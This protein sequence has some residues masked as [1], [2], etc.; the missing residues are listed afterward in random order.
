MPKDAR[1][2]HEYTLPDSGGKVPR[3]VA[4]LGLYSPDWERAHFPKLKAVGHFESKVFD[5]D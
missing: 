3:S 2:G 1:F 4:S 5:P